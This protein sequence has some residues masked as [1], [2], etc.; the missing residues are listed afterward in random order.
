MHQIVSS[1]PA[2]IGGLEENY[3]RPRLYGLIL[4]TVISKKSPRTENKHMHA[5]TDSMLAKSDM[6]TRMLLIC[7]K[8][9]I[10]RRTR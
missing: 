4:N 5:M 8:L 3:T 7:F 2:L 1:V 9:R 10:Q 6:M